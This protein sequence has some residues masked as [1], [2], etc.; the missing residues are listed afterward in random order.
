MRAI[1]V[2][3]MLA[4]AVSVCQAKQPQTS[5]SA[6]SAVNTL[7]NIAA[8]IKADRLLV[9]KSDR[10]LILFKGTTEIARYTNIRLGDAPTG[11]KQFEGDEKTPEGSYTISGR[12]PGSSYHRS[13][14]ISYPNAA[15]TAYAKAKGKSPGGDIFIH[16]QPNRWKGDPIARDWTDGCIALSNAEIEQLW[17]VVPDGAKIV[18]KP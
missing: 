3:I 12:N 16:G 8:G 14:K 15:D 9:D 4:G 2:S 13:L 18:I 5:P 10:T 11:H 17:K 1:I 6:P 7:P